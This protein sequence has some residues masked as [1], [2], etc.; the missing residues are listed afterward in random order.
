MK[1]TELTVTQQLVGGEHAAL[2]WLLPGTHTS[3]SLNT[4]WGNLF[5]TS[6]LH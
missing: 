5:Q 2:S 1:A 3:L 6:A 4:E